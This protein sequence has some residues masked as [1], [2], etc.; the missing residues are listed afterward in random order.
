MKVNIGDVSIKRRGD[1]LTIDY[2][3]KGF[4]ADLGIGL[5]ISGS[6]RWT[7]DRSLKLVS[8]REGSGRDRLGEYNYTARVYAIPGL[9][10]DVVP[11]VQQKLKVYDDSHLLIETTALEDIVGLSLEDSFYTTTFNS[12]VL[13]LQEALN[14]LTYTWGLIATESSRDGGHFPEAVT[15]KGISSIPSKLCLAGYS[16]REDLS[17]ISDKPFGPLVVYDDDG[18]TLLIS[19]F[20]HF[21]ISPLRTIQT[22]S[23]FGIARGLH[24]L[25]DSLPKGATTQTALV[26]GEGVVE[27]MV[28]WGDWLM[29]TGG[30]TRA[31]P[32]DN[33]LLRQA[34]DRLLGQI[35]FWNCFGGYYTELFRR[36]DENVLKE[37][38]EYFREEGIPVRYFGLDLWYDYSE[39]GFALSYK[40]DG[41]KYPRGLEAIHQE[42]GLPYLLHMSAFESSNDYVGL[43]EFAVDESSAYPIQRGLYEELARDFKQWGG[44]GIWPDFLRT[45]MQNSRSLRSTIDGADDWF[46]SLAGAFGEEGMAIMMCMPTIGHYLASTR[47]QNISAVRTHTDYLNHQKNQVEALRDQGLRYYLPPQRSIR[48]NVLLSLL[49]HS[50]GLC[51]SFDVFLTNSAHPEGFAEPNAETEALLRA[52]SAGVI[53]VGDK[54]GSIDKNIIKKLCFPDGNTSRPDHPPLPL[55]ST[56]QSDVLA[57]YTTATVGKFKWVYLALFNVSEEGAR[58]K[59][60][61]H[62]QLGTHGGPIFDYFERRVL[63]ESGLEGYLEPAQGRY[64]VIMPRVG[65]AYFLGFPDRYITVSSRQVTGI[66]ASDG[67]VTVNFQLPASRPAIGAP[68][69]SG[70][71]SEPSSGRV[72]PYETVYTLALISPGGL[73]LK[74]DVTASGGDVRSVRQ[75][76]ELL[77]I[78][79]TAVS[80]GAS[81][82]FRHL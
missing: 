73:P 70:S 21:L 76:G 65:D 38:A 29:S 20:N 50:L 22:P 10:K 25:V 51:P 15:G 6:W 69:L 43:H 71:P 57:F 75:E 52:M 68:P 12:P 54:A 66:Q 7:F 11:L 24:G 36:A 56:L 4:V 32:L 59:L 31:G 53:A 67:E 42:T 18:R 49:A 40:P 37:L 1:N 45:Q 27:T 72:A 39:I 5:P 55:V 13:L 28:K 60:D 80:E 17:S 14:Y 34:Q 44:F 26:F 30:K 78:D 58:Y 33:P 64:Y 2:H 63:R 46:D 41:V 48:H 61:V 16:P 79:F 81:L 77:Y 19:P 23:G 62:E 47:H 9:S 82:T 35:G 74:L 8:E 3:G